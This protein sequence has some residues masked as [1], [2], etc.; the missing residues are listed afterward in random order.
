MLEDQGPRYFNDDGTEFDPDLIP[1]PDLC[2]SCVSHNVADGEENMLCN[3][4]KAD[5]QE[6]K[7]FLC[8]AYRPIS[9]SIDRE[10]VLRE[11]CEQAGMEYPEGCDGSDSMPF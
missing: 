11:L 7:V 4:T 10:A 1:T 9:P 8:F 5:Q 2:I 3:L 6:D